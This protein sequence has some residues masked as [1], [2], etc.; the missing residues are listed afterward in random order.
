MAGNERPYVGPRPF[1]RAEAH[2]YFGRDREASDL[3][4][5]ITAH[6]EVL[7]YAQSGAG[8]TSLVRAKLVPDLEREGFDVLPIARV[9]SLNLA[10]VDTA[11][12]SN[13]YV[14]SVLTNWASDVPPARLAKESL[15]EHLARHRKAGGAHA[16]KP[17][18]L[19]LD[20]FE[21]LFTLYPDRWT[22]RSAFFRQVR[23]ALSADPLLR[24]VFVMREEF[25]A[26]LDPHVSVLREKLRTRFY[27]ERLH[28]P[29]ALRAVAGP[30][31]GTGY[32]FAPGV[33][34]RLVEDLLESTVELETG[35]RKT[36]KGEFCE[37]VQLQ[38][39]CERLWRELPP[40]VT[41]ITDAHL[42]KSGNLDKA[43]ADL[44]EEIIGDTSRQQRVSQSRLRRWVEEVLITPAGTRGTVFR[45]KYQTGGLPN[46]AIDALVSRHLLRGESRG[47][48]LWYELPHDSFIGPIRRANDRWRRGH[49]RELVMSWAREHRRLAAITGLFTLL[50]LTVLAGGFARAQYK[51]VAAAALLMQQKKEQA[52][53]E[54]ETRR[55]QEITRL[56]H[57]LGEQARQEWISGHDA[58]AAVLLQ[59]AFQSKADAPGLRFLLPETLRAFTS[60]LAEYR[61]HIAGMSSI[62]YHPLGNSILTGSRDG[63]AKLWDA[64]TGQL[65][66]S[67]D[68]H[69]AE[70]TAVAFSPDGSRVATA[71]RD[72]TGRVWDVLSGGFVVL[73]GHGDLVNGVAF[74]PT[75]PD[76]VM[77]ASSDGTVRTW[78]HTARFGETNGIRKQT[79][80]AAKTAKT[81]SPDLNATTTPAPEKHA[82]ATTKEVP[83]TASRAEQI[84]SIRMSQS[85]NL[86]AWSISVSRDGRY[87]AVACADNRTRVFDEAD[88]LKV[89][90]EHP[91]P[92]GFVAFVTDSGH[93]RILTVGTRARIWDVGGI[94]NPPS[95]S[96]STTRSMTP[97]RATRPTTAPT[98]RRR[99][100]TQGTALSAGSATPP[101][102]VVA[103]WVREFGGSSGPILAAA[104][105][106][107][108]RWLATADSARSLTL[109]DA[110]GGSPVE[111][112]EGIDSDVTTIAFA[113]DGTSLAS[114]GADAVGHIWDL[115]DARQTPLPHAPGRVVSAAGEAGKMFELRQAGVDWAAFSVDGSR[116]VTAGQDRTAKVWDS[117]S[118]ALLHTLPH[119]RWV[120]TA[121]FS[122]D[123]RWVATGSG[124]TIRVWTLG[125][126]PRAQPVS[127][128]AHEDNI[129]RLAFNPAGTM[130][131][132]S[133][134][135]KRWALW[136]PRQ[137]QLVVRKEAPSS[138]FTSLTFS[139]DGALL[140][141]GGYDAALWDVKTG[142]TRA[143]FDHPKL[144]H[145]VFS[146]DG[147][148]VVT[149]DARGSVRVFS[150]AASAD[151][152]I[153]PNARLQFTHKPFTRMVGV[154]G[155]ATLVAAGAGDG[156][157]TVW[158]VK[159]GK[160]VADFRDAQSPVTA[161]A[162]GPQ[163][164]T[165]T[166]HDDGS[167][168]GWETSTGRRL[169]P[170]QGHGD[171]VRQLVFDR[172]GRRAVSA[173][174]DGTARIWN[175]GTHRYTPEEADAIVRER[176]R[177]RL[178]ERGQLSPKPTSR[179]T[180]APGEAGE[181]IEKGRERLL[182]RDWAAAARLFDS[183]DGSA[184]AAPA[185]RY[186]AARARH[187]V[188]EP[189]RVLVGRRTPA[190]SIS[191]SSGSGKLLTSGGE[192]AA[193]LWDVESGHSRT[194][195]GHSG[196]IAKSVFSHDGR[197]I[198]TASEDGTARLWDT[199]SG[200]CTATLSH[201][202]PV[203][204]ARFSPDDKVVATCSADG[205]A[206]LWSVADG[207]PLRTFKHGQTDVVNLNFNRDGLRVVTC[208][209][210]KKVRIWNV[211]QERVGATIEQDATYA[212]FSPT[213]GL[214]AIDGVDATTGE[215]RTYLWAPGATEPAVTMGFKFIAFNPQGAH[216]LL[217]KDDEAV[218]ADAAT[219]AVLLTLKGNGR[220]VNMC[221]FSADGKLVIIGGSDSVVRIWDAATGELT[222]RLTGMPGVD[223]GSVMATISSDGQRLAGGGEGKFA[224]WD[225]ARV[226]AP[227]RLT[228]ETKMMW[229]G[230][231]EGG[232]VVVAAEPA[233]DS[234]R[235]VET[236]PAMSPSTAPA[237]ATQRSSENED[238]DGDRDDRALFE[239][240]AEPPPQAVAPTN[241][242]GAAAVYR[243]AEKQP[244]SK[245]AFGGREI[246]HLEVHP[247]GSTAVGVDRDGVLLRWSLPGGGEPSVLGRDASSLTPLRFT[248][249]A[250]R[251]LT[252]GGRGESGTCEITIWDMAAPANPRTFPCRHAGRINDLAL[253]SDG[254]RIITASADGSA[255]VWDVNS[256]RPVCLLYGHRDEVR[257][258]A[259]TSDGSRILTA[260]ADGTARV[261][262]AAS[263][264]SLLELTGHRSE[265]RSA[266][267]SRDDALILT[268]GADGT[269]RVW[270]A[271]TGTELDRLAVQR[272]GYSRARF[273]PD[274]NR[275]LVADTAGVVEELVVG[276][277]APPETSAR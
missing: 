242:P 17:Q 129:V 208:A 193:T 262:D 78:D 269:V 232:P 165:L 126:H 277:T 45:G 41:E 114:G 135:D 122:P 156:E 230:Y 102:V 240:L 61:G 49:I 147:S 249:D 26:R 239:E 265:V 243:V 69:L 216:V 142:K 111:R 113:P 7:L 170:W 94:L 204:R 272:A 12:V 68:G 33:A 213:T 178:D 16:E 253:S 133:S 209:A 46:A 245:L 274:G 30:L 59:A 82:P 48:G 77:T 167:V 138:I 268:A 80:I 155:D 83:P 64:K 166:G 194:L 174:W 257:A 168:I 226:P 3:V 210:D 106:P 183:L 123:G 179:P 270:D 211:D 43:L 172:H 37:P 27:L 36:I 150:T 79:P 186:M 19:I 275:V 62:A 89:L 154:S 143:V 175:V 47:G 96:S 256:G 181:T 248:P 132:S 73:R 86:E 238:P 160:H 261:W 76:R 75:D 139:G 115:R 214:V 28:E 222:G 244:T 251:L 157:V 29:E 53:A 206:R 85:N 144:S 18:V 104:V 189:L 229:A 234:G 151:G 52:E 70:I 116:V 50:L 236:R 108:G 23:A 136:D 55:V 40:G 241:A 109:W 124:N 185:V 66:A 128:Q 191:F 11:E 42:T 127:W 260:S 218:L 158:N 254:T 99:P 198:A 20:Q 38:V 221:D 51:A 25:V 15:A 237:A 112:F 110:V 149:A 84:G 97:A 88:R 91:E 140:F 130:L 5:L 81:E 162:I 258:V 271:Q 220:S 188:R 31:K 44:Y 219:G 182:A 171:A 2:L 223:Q 152:T 259:C 134:R 184:A 107:D 201:G 103:K 137:G 13:I 90:L 101:G 57:Q 246:T 8:K 264:R 233:A 273:S 92:V 212:E 217:A 164:V 14:F 200:E 105:S 117:A 146:A 87:Y 67:F 250:R 231:T 228:C 65:L 71:S 60:Q 190:N 266:E 205:T 35:E 180:L 197:R 118:G 119:D 195:A 22:D 247:A 58:R 235:P 225:P 145:A 161:I 153:D 39:V 21:E 224:V 202:K 215:P 32:R 159:E 120:S 199:A 177:F 125:A 173:S 203:H 252:A 267:F 34:E 93:D 131:A 54:S 100:A 56:G 192:N 95:T 148:T 10:D 6:S 196:P 1:E 255:K 163:G 72:H 187:A 227:V 121:V 207:R 169:T 98:T 9:R 141:T 74:H 63:T 176:A 24:V 263:G 276:P 4:S